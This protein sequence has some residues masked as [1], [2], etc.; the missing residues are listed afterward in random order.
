MNDTMKTSENLFFTNQNYRLYYASQ[1]NVILLE[2]YKS[3]KLEVAREAW[4]KA[5]DK[6]EEHQVLKWISDE[7]QIELI[8]HDFH[9]WW[10]AEWYPYS[11]KRLTFD[12]KRLAATILSHRF[13]AEMSTKNT[14]NKTLRLKAIVGQQNKYMEHLYFKDFVEAYDWITST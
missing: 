9:S 1:S 6:A 10:V 8:S 14:V 13:Y 12:G 7:A 5:L 2:A 4:L 11:K 3:I